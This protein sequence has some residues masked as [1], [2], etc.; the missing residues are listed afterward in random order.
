M[1]QKSAKDLKAIIKIASHYGQVKQ[2]QQTV[3]ECSELIQAICKSWRTTPETPAPE[4]EQTREHIIEEMADVQIMLWQLYYL[5]IPDSD[6][7]D[8]RIS[9]KLERQL[10]RIEEERNEI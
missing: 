2:T 9:E 3:E 10:K 5:M 6:E 7:M 4:F 8:R 1:D